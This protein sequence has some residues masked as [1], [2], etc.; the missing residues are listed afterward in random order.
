MLYASIKKLG[1]DI[2]EIKKELMRRKP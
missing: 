2:E 1:R